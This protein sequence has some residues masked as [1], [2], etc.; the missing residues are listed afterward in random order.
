MSAEGREIVGPGYLVPTCT[1]GQ[2]RLPRATSPR[3]A[4]QVKP[5]HFGAKVDL[6]RS[7]LSL[8]RMRKYKLKMNPVNY[9]FAM[10]AGRFLGFIV[11]EKQIQIDPKKVEAISKMEEPMCKR[12]MSKLLGKINYLRRFTAKLA[13]KIDSFLLLLELNHEGEIRWGGGG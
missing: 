7:G 6:A 11:H 13:G 4:C 5:V 10:T 9:A 12:D 8:E 2:R 1:S 3:G